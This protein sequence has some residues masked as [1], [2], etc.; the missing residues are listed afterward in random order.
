[1]QNRHAPRFGEEPETEIRSLE[2]TIP[3]QKIAS[4]FEIEKS[5]EKFLPILRAPEGITPETKRKVI[6]ALIHEIR[7]TR[8][9]FE[10]HFYVASD[11]IKKGEQLRSPL[12]SLDKNFSVRGSLKDLNGGPT[13]NRTWN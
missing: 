7:I 13:K 5:F 6:H 4:D 8:D 12:K 9:G 3:A 11:Q 1:M 10:M 2:E